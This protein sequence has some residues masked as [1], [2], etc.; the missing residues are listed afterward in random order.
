MRVGGHDAVAHGVAVRDQRA[1]QRD[2]HLTR[3]AGGGARRAD[4][5]ANPVAVDDGDIG[6]IEDLHG[7][8]EAQHDLRRS[9]LDP[10]ADG[11][12]GP[13]QRGVR[14]RGRGGQPR[15]CERDERTRDGTA[16]RA[17]PGR[18]S[19]VVRRSR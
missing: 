4:V 15:R 19:G 13:E 11:G 10:A 6:G 2:H 1:A 14:S 16:P 8:A 9:D 5:D 3:V 18:V 7:L 12:R 17:H